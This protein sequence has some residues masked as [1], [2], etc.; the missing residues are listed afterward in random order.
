M[1]KLKVAIIGCGAIYKNHADALIDN[2]YAELKYVVDINESKAKEAAKLYNCEYLTDFQ[3][4]L[5]NPEIDAIDICTP[6]YLHAPMAIAAMKAGKHV[7]TEKPMS[8]AVKEAEEMI[9]VAKQYN[10]HLGVCFQNRFNSTTVKALEVLNSGTLGSVKGIKGF[11]T[12][13]RDEKYYTESGW[14]GS[15]KTEG[16][17]V[18]INQAIHTI[19]LMQWIG[20]GVE[21]LKAN[22]DTRTL[23]QVIEVEDTADAT[24]VFKNGAKGIFYCTNSYTTNSP[25]EIEIHCDKGNLHIIDE[26]LYLVKDGKKENLATDKI[27][28]NKYKSYWG[29]SHSIL[30]AK[31]YEAV[32][33]NDFSTYVSGE[34]G[35]ATIKIIDAIYK[36]SAGHKWINL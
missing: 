23:S 20:G 9:T 24:I 21:K 5:D 27:G 15:F 18:L 34:D 36:S 26:E 32:Y 16:G 35:I 6:H 22:V 25:V 13:I 7:F 14:R 17:G 10:R 1:N 28:N 3:Q 30:I 19:D 4:I 33:N 2:N 31:F 29:L 12:W 11:V 8:I